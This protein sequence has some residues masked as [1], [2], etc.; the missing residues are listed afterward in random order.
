MQIDFVSPSDNL[1]VSRTLILGGDGHGVN[2]VASL[3]LIEDDTSVT[4]IDILSSAGHSCFQSLRHIDGIVYIGFGAHVFTLNLKS[5]QICRHRLLAYFG[6]FYDE[7]DLEGLDG[8]FSLIATSD[9]EVLAFARTGELLWKQSG[10]GL[11][12]IVLHEIHAGQLAGDGE[13]DPPG[14]WEPFA[15]MLDSGRV[16]R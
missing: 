14:G 3:R 11:D 13:W 4:R 5:R 2:V 15:L 9:S 8:R 1:E 16:L 10:L 6:H 7:A 12:G